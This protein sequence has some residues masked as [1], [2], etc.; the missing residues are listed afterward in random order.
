MNTKIN[1]YFLRFWIANFLSGVG[2]WAYYAA[3]TITV[4]E[5]YH[6][7]AYGIWIA[8][9]SA[10]IVI[11]S[12]LCGIVVDRFSQKKLLFGGYL[13]SGII[14]LF[15]IFL[16]SF[17]AISIICIIESA[18]STL[19]YIAARAY[20]RSLS[21]ND[22]HIIKYHSWTILSQLL[23]NL[24]GSFCGGILAKQALLPTIIYFNLV[25]CIVAAY[26]LGY[27]ASS[28][29]HSRTYQET[30]P[31]N[32]KFYDSLPYF[33]KIWGLLI[34]SS[35]CYGFITNYIVSFWE[36]LFKGEDNF[37]GCSLGISGLGTLFG[38]FIT[39]FLLSNLP[40]NFGIKLLSLGSILI[41]CCSY[42]L[43]ITKQ[44]LLFLTIIFLVN[45]FYASCRS[46]SNICI[47]RLVKQQFQGRALSITY[48]ILNVS[49][50]LTSL[51][52][53]YIISYFG[54]TQSLTYYVSLAGS[55]YII[56]LMFTKNSSNSNFGDINYKR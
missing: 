6:P 13:L 7:K 43:G 16:P 56:F 50:L 2:R 5:N 33:I 46:I 14:P 42:L 26:I 54:V 29:S 40:N 24:F 27:K 4:Y 48:M 32:L 49:L 38:I 39:K 23:P 12:P 25:G 41:I 34:S 31:Q 21:E 3:L 20:I 35:I 22:K 52:A 47:A 11:A 30:E 8:L 10:S 19:L 53:G 28:L 17:I 37:Y 51:S 18:F 55:I 9:Y 1:L 44:K 15:I 36:E 45:V